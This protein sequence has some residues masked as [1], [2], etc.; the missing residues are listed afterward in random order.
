MFKKLILIL[1]ILIA[2]SFIL[3]SDDLENTEKDLNTT[4]LNLMDYLSFTHYLSYNTKNYTNFHDGNKLT[5]NINESQNFNYEFEFE[6]W[7]DVYENDSLIIE[8]DFTNYLA[9]YFYHKPSAQ[10]TDFF[11]GI[12]F[13]HKWIS[14]FNTSFYFTDQFEM[15]LVMGYQ[16]PFSADYGMEYS[17]I[18]T[19]IRNKYYPSDYL[20]I[21]F[22]LLTEI[23]STSGYRDSF[24]RLML[25]PTITFSNP[26]WNG[27]EKHKPENTYPFGF[28]WAFSEDIILGFNLAFVQNQNSG[29]KD[30]D[31]RYGVE[32]GALE[33]FRFESYFWLKQDIIKALDNAGFIENKWLHLSLFAEETVTIGFPNMWGPS[34]NY[35]TDNYPEEPVDYKP[36]FISFPFLFTSGLYGVH[37][38]FFGMSLK[39]ALSFASQD[40]I[41]T[42]IPEDGLTN[43]NVDYWDFG[44]RY[45]N[46]AQ[47]GGQFSLEYASRQGFTF[48]FTYHGFANIRDYDHDNDGFSKAYENGLANSFYNTD[49]EGTGY[50]WNNHFTLS[51]KYYY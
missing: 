49:W 11:Q 18:N 2:I 41:N 50:P 38:S 36:Y 43:S 42:D 28:A 3:N 10:D 47:L 4:A 8:I 24:T 23:R 29:I 12:D 25:H 20:A 39:L 16:M 1:F 51:A 26:E 37:L 17:E 33:Q 5:N 21:G 31:E 13:S 9:N 15:H 48:G 14:T 6:F 32:E 35:T 34:I 30:D 7:T 44:P 46:R 27:S 45:H 22:D 19:G 40:A